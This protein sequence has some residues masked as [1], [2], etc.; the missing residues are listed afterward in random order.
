MNLRVVAAISWKDIVDSIRNRYLLVALLTPLLVAV[1]FRVLLPGLTNVDSLT[2]VVHDPGSSRLV[3]ELRPI[4]LVKLVE[5]GSAE[6]VATDVEKSKAVGGLAIPANF[7][8][9]VAAGKEPELTVYLNNK[10]NAIE[11]ATFRQVL[12]RQV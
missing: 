4:P 5:A 11:Q 2:I 10:K 7:D 6:A 12:E 3:S 8:V 9:D 1:L